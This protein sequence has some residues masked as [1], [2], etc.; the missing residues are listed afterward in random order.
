MPS[1]GDRDGVNRDRGVLFLSGW[2]LLRM[3]VQSEGDFGPGRAPLLDER[4]WGSRGG[5]CMLSHGG[6]REL[7]IILEHDE[8]RAG[9]RCEDGQSIN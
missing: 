2:S 5:K 8:A 1:L 3:R 6:K 9:R 4:L 7:W